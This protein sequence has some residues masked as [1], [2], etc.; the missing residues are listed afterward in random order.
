[1]TP[2]VE[3]QTV[4]KTK[5]RFYHMEIVVGFLIT[6]VRQL[7][8]ILLQYIHCRSKYW[9][10]KPCAGF[11]TAPINI[12]Q[13][14]FRYCHLI[15]IEN[16][17]VC[18]GKTCVGRKHKQVAHTFQFSSKWKFA[19]LFQL[20]LREWRALL[21][22]AMLDSNTGIGIMVYLLGFHKLTHPLVNLLVVA[23]A[24]HICTGAVLEPVVKVHDFCR[25]EIPVSVQL[26]I[27]FYGIYHNTLVLPSPMT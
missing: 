18:I 9:R 6:D 4:Y 12:V 24:S 10:E 16:L 21:A 11:Y 1:M 2:L 3:S 17:C 22:L 7:E 23:A 5:L 15:K 8:I 19:Q 26:A 13:S 27:A 20:I 25:S 14:I